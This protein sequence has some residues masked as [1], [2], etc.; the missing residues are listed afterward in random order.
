MAQWLSELIEI[1]VHDPQRIRALARGRPRRTELAP[2]GHLVLVAADHPAR[3]VLAAGSDPWAMADRADLL[4]RLATV[5]SQP[6]VDGLLAT[7]DIVDELLLLNALRM[8]QG[9]QDFLAHKVLIGS[10]NRGGL[11]GTSFELLDPV[12]AYRAE[13]LVEMGLDA[14]KL[15][16]RLDPTSRDAASTLRWCAEALHD[17]DRHQLPAFLEP[18]AVPSNT[19]DLVRLVGVAT[20]LGPSSAHLWLKLPMVPDFERVARAST[21]PIVLLGGDRAG[22]PQ[23]LLADVARCLQAG[24]NV[25]GVLIGRGLLYPGARL[26]PAQQVSD[27]VQLVHQGVAQ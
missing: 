10:M 9:H 23:Q 24:P 19:D 18:L 7:P 11:A 25:R 13:A 3:R 21:C 5:L 2:D 4:E 16:L 15:L 14:G 1:R 22:G 12:T 20:A 17:L 8:E 6:G 26:D 27:I